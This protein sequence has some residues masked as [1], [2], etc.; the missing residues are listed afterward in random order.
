MD[1]KKFID[2][3]KLGTEDGLGKYNS[4]GTFEIF[5][6]HA[7]T[8]L[9]G[10][11]KFS[12]RRRGPIF[13]RGQGKDYNSMKPTL[14]R[15]SQSRSSVQSRNEAISRYIKKMIDNE[16]FMKSTE[17]VAYEPLLQHYGVKTTWIDVVDNIWTALWFACHK[18]FS[19]GLGGKYVHYEVSHEDYAYIYIMYFGV[20]NK[21]F[22]QNIIR[23]I[24]A[25]AKYEGDTDKIIKE[26][27]NAFFETNQYR[28]IDLRYMVPSLYRRP[29]SQHAI[30]ARRRKFEK[31]DDMDYKDTI[32]GKL[33]IKTSLVFEWLGNGFLTKTHFM[34]PP[35]VYDPGYKLFLEK[36]IEPEASQFGCIQYIFA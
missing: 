33:K 3:N 7:L 28:V 20:M 10:Y 32:I 13:F 15:D 27:T 11:I 6:P 8:Q 22:S 18:G 30:L 26:P 16:A 2:W 34:F 36:G 12:Y 24:T 25:L 1:K 21:K 31:D 19:T 17:N 4:D 5:S 29:H 14:L 35:P 23:K 9:I